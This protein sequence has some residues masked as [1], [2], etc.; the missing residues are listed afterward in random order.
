[1][2]SLE[3]CRETKLWF[4][5]SDP[6][7]KDWHM[8]QGE[9][10]LK[11]EHRGMGAKHG[12]TIAR[13]DIPPF[14]DKGIFHCRTRLP[15]GRSTSIPLFTSE[16]GPHSLALMRTLPHFS[17]PSQS[18]YNLMIF[19]W[20]MNIN[21][22]IKQSIVFYCLVGPGLL[23]HDGVHSRAQNDY[24]QSRDERGRNAWQT[25]TPSGNSRAIEMDMNG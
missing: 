5:S 3:G 25:R 22:V 6:L 2:L 16:I 18:V 10:W 23:S 13:L 24:G 4:A 12:K 9:W 8:G 14:P 17:V 19:Y 7:L 15:E 1:M 21:T 20:G 11:N